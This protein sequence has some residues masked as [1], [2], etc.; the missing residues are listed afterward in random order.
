MVVR[1]SA[2]GAL[3]YARGSRSKPLRRGRTLGVRL[4]TAENGQKE[5]AFGFIKQGI[6]PKTGL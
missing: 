2:S 4:T 5:A 1:M 6:P 3:T